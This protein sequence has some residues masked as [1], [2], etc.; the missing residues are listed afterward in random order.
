MKR[1]IIGSMDSG[2]GKTSLIIGLAKASG[3]SFGYMKPLGDRLVYRKKHVWD[4]DAALMSNIFNLSQDPEDIT[5]G[6]EH[7]KMAFKYNEEAAREKVVE[8][9]EAVAADKDI[10]F[11]EGGKDISYGASFHLNVLSLARYLDGKLIL[12]VSGD[13]NNILD[14]VVFINRYLSLKDITLGGVIINKVR[15]IDD[16][17]GIYVPMI[18]KEGVPILGIIPFMPDLTFFSMEYLVQ[19]LFARV[20]TGEEWLNRRINT[21]FV[22]AASV[23]AVCTDTQFQRGNKLVI[24]SGDRSDLL[25]ASFED[26]CT[27]AV[28]VTNNILPPQNILAKADENKV[29]V[30]L[31]PSGAY[32]TA[33]QIEALTP[34]I[35]SQNSGEIDL[36]E[37]MVKTHINVDA[38]LA[39]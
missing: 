28:I 2:S 25:L 36:M 12:V 3:K 24:V 11:V 19:Y 16:F 38:L 10:L 35:T 26:R 1:V 9:S 27:S 32:E 5:L 22:G 6:F 31:V 7:L 34:M 30:L 37:K 17:K 29:P 4:Y 8:L 21:I 33:K 39:G 20:L 13:E 23:D 18:Q 15:N 14:H